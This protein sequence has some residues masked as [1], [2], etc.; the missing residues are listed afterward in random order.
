MSADDDRRLGVE[1]L[2]F[3]RS[4]T[5][6]RPS[7]PEAVQI[8]GAMR[9][10]YFKRDQRLFAI[11][12]PAIDVFFIVKGSVRLTAPDAAPWDFEAPAVIGAI[13]AFAGRPRTRRAVATADTHALALAHTDWLAVLEEHFDFARESVLRLADGLGRMRLGLAGDGGHPGPSEPAGPRAAGLGLYE[14]TVALR[15]LPVLR[16]AGVQ[17]TMRLAALAEERALAPGEALFR[18]GDAG[19]TLD[20][21]AGGRIAIERATPPLRA[22]F[23]AGSLVGGLASLAAPRAAFDAR[24]AETSLVLRLRKDDVFDVMEDHFELTRSI[25]AS[26]NEERS[27]LM[28]RHGTLD[29]GAAPEAA[30][31]AGTRLGGPGAYP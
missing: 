23:G 1:R 22:A 26:V 7:G 9:D 18:E 2:L 25:L 5:N 6:A 13:D 3:L 24:A 10:L 4:L 28:A 15:R 8:A 27:A 19:E 31:G 20:A 14:K 30:P 17:V 12:D 11:G 29:G 21:V 16:A